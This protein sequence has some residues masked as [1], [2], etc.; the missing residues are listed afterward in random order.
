VIFILEPPI[1]VLNL[2][3]GPITSLKTIS[4]NPKLTPPVIEPPPPPPVALIVMSVPDG[5]STEVIVILFP[6]I[7]VGL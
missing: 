2:R 7:K 3:L 6:A 5:V 4:P 1:K